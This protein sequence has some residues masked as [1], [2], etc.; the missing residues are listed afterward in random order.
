[1]TAQRSQGNTFGTPNQVTTQSAQSI[2]KSPGSVTAE[3]F[4][5]NAIK[6][7]G[8]SD[9]STTDTPNSMYL[10]SQKKHPDLYRLLLQKIHE[11]DFSSEPKSIVQINILW[12]IHAIRIYV[13]GSV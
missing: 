12:E 4:I 8:I 11:I 9:S 2:Y 13:K 6:S 10:I 1:M 5:L 3:Q 7:S